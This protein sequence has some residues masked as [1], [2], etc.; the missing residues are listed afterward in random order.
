MPRTRAT[1]VENI[2][3]YIR[4]DASSY[5]QDFVPQASVDADNLKTIGAVIMGN[6]TLRNEFLSALV[7]RIGFVTIT[8]KYWESP[9]SIFLKGMVEYGQTT[10]EIFVNLA[11]P[12]TYD[13]E[14]GV[15]NQYKVETPDVRSA[16]HVMNWQK[17]FKTTVFEKD[18]KQAFLSWDGV[19]DLISKIIESLT[20]SLQYATYMTTKYMIARVLLKGQGN[21]T[22]IPAVT[23]DNMK[24]IIAQVKTIS[25]N[26]TILNNKNNLAG[27]M[28]HTPK[29]DQYLIL[30]NE[31]DATMDVEVLASAFNMDKTEFY[32]HRILIDGFGEIDNDYMEQL[33]T[34][35]SGVVDP[36]YIPLTAEEKQAL[37]TIPAIMV[38]GS[39]MQ[40][41]QNMHE[42]TE[43]FNAESIYWNYWLHEWMTFSVSPF[44]QRTALVPGAPTVTAIELSPST[45]S[46]SVGQKVQIT[47]NVTATNFAS[48]SV[49]F[50]VDDDTIATVD[51]TGLVTGLAAGTVTVTATSVVDPSVTDTAE[52][53]I[54]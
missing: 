6:A 42:M 34:N 10:E 41:Y 45:A 50:T 28:N 31:F 7:N 2:L 23:V 53:T 24:S 30:T 26:W 29:D 4:Q 38:D 1:N 51:V 39:F 27:V 12:F 8:S 48:K 40:I 17:F 13:P 54:A 3:N 49:R 19:S 22:Q 37:N 16:F 44:A 5:Y 35:T 20:T 18:L 32:G 14:A 21:A 33:F 43:K 11:K 47:A 46:I 25:N 15:D 36:A 9:L 52:I